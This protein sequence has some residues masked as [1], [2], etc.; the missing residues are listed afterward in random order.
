MLRRAEHNSPV[1]RPAKQASLT[2]PLLW[3]A[4]A[5]MAA[6][7][8]AAD[9]G[10]EAANLTKQESELPRLEIASP[11]DRPPYCI[12]LETLMA[13]ADRIKA[14]V[15]HCPNSEYAGAASEWVKKQAEYVKLF[16][17]NRCKR[18]L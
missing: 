2:A 1:R 4:S 16:G 7:A 10:I 9:C 17:Q 12:T 11:R 18:T 3:W 6:A 13:F 8:P 15:G 5:L 14:H